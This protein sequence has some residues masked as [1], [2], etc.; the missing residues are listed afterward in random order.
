MIMEVA[1]TRNAAVNNSG[2]ELSSNMQKVHVYS[3]RYTNTVTGKLQ[4]LLFYHQEKDM[5]QNI[6]ASFIWAVNDSD[7]IAP[8]YHEPKFNEKYEG[9]FAEEKINNDASF[10]GMKPVACHWKIIEKTT[11]KT[12]SSGPS[13]TNDAPSTSP[14]CSTNDDVL[15]SLALVYLSFSG[16]IEA[17]NSRFEYGFEQLMR[18]AVQPAIIL[19]PLDGNAIFTFSLIAVFFLIYCYFVMTRQK[20]NWNT[21]SAIVG[22]FILIPFY[23]YYF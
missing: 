9:V 19:K 14:S 2:A 15:F 1:Q 20:I 21:F 23:V 3:L 18:R 17:F 7:R 16:V 22:I 8:R 12:I 13:A 11:N 10:Y 6:A 4:L 5:A